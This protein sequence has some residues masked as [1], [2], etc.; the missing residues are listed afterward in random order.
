MKPGDDCF[1]LL[2]SHEYTQKSIEGLG[3]GA[4]KGVDRARFQ[5]LEEAN[6]SVPAEKK[7]EFHVVELHH[8]VV[9][10]G[11]YGNIGDWDEESREEKTRWYTTQGRALGSGRTAKFNFL[12][13]CNE[14]LAQ[15]WKKP[16]GSSNMHGYMG[17]E[18]PTKE[19][20]YCRFAVVAWPEVKSR[21]HKTNF[22]G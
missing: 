16:Y 2:L 21:E 9:F 10:Y 12:N 18:G 1:A 17:N 13:P 15:M 22:I 3:A 7:L 6:A 4:L 19:T 20:K 14:T 11:R 5:A 8:E